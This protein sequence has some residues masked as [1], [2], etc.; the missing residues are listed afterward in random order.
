[1]GNLRSYYIN[2]KIVINGT[3]KA[4]GEITSLADLIGKGNIEVLKTINNENYASSIKIKYGALSKDF[5]DFFL[6]SEQIPTLVC[7]NPLF[8]NEG[9]L[10]SSYG[11]VIQTFPDS[12]DTDFSFLETLSDKLKKV[13]YHGDFNSFF[14]ELK[15][16]VEYLETTDII[17]KCSCN[18]KVIIQ[19]LKMLDKKEI[20]DEYSE[21]I[22]EKCGKKYLIK[23]EDICGK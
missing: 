16:E 12:T 7:L 19:T 3:Q 10:Y 22:C 9:K 11:L 23:N 14:E 13:K 1:M 8:D 20:D 21:V 15:I 2:G 4:I 5:S 18:R 6:V 17:Y